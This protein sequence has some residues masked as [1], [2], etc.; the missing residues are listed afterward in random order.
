M[1]GTLITSW[2]KNSLVKWLLDLQFYIIFVNMELKYS[3]KSI[4]MAEYFKSHTDELTS[5][6][7][8]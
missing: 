7:A 4:L 2:V 8:L 1:T 6:N 3:L 5:L